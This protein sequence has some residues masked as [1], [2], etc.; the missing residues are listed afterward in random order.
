MLSVGK[1]AS[2]IDVLPSALRF[3]EKLGLEPRGGSKDLSLFMLFQ[4]VDED[5]QN[6]AEDWMSQISSRWTARILCSFFH[7]HLLMFYQAQN[8]GKLSFGEAS[9]CSKPGLIPSRLD[10]FRKTFSKT[11]LA[12]FTLFL[13]SSYHQSLYY[14]P[15]CS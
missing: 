11:N 4:P 10:T 15:S 14:R 6:A 7:L 1:S 8:L 12:Y 13:T 5:R 3:W 2:V 9:V